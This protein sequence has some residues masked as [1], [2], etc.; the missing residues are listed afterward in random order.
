MRKAVSGLVP[1]K[2]VTRRRTLNFYDTAREILKDD[3]DVLELWRGRAR[4]VVIRR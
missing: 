3:P 1:A 4:R 2:A